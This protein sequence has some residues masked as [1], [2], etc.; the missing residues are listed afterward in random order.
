MSIV[1]CW[2]IIPNVLDWLIDRIGGVEG[3]KWSMLLAGVFVAI[4]VPIGII[5]LR[6][7][8]LEQ[9]HLVEAERKKE[10]A[11]KEK[12][13]EQEKVQQTIE[14]GTVTNNEG[15]QKKET[16]T[17]H[18]PDAI[19]S[20]PKVV[21]SDDTNGG[22]DGEKKKDGENDLEARQKLLAPAPEQPLATPAVEVKEEKKKSCDIAAAFAYFLHFPSLFQNPTYLIHA[23][24]FAVIMT[25]DNIFLSITFDS[26]L[27]VSVGSR[28]CSILLVKFIHNNLNEFGV[29]AA[30]N[31]V[32]F[33]LGLILPN[34]L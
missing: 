11:A 22:A 29:E 25:V 1:L 4:T 21:T 6:P 30:V 31:T 20:E 27:K 12:E 15:E 2:Q 18:D 5:F 10:A 32:Y 26:F 14:L 3:M 16:D 13:Q 17:D 33:S 24:H 28:N 7:I 19:T 23:L 8:T 9:L 34:I